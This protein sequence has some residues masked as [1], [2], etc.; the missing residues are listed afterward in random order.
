MIPAYVSISRFR[1]R[2][3]MEEEVAE[4]FRARPHLV[5]DASGF[6]RMEVLSPAEDAARHLLVGRGQLPRLAPRT[7]VPRLAR[8]HPEG[9]EARRGRHGVARVP[10]R[11][12][13]TIN[14]GAPDGR[15]SG[16]PS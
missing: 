15:R 14:A 13:M 1:V 6:I 3:G 2:N 5:D 12:V 9:T 4:A 8:R 16:P 7:H 11:G 10:V